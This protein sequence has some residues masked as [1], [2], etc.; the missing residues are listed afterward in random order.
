VGGLVAYVASFRLDVSFLLPFAAGNFV[1]IAASDLV[2][3]IN[4]PYSLTAN[5]LHFV[6][7]LAGLLLLLVIK[8]VL[9]NH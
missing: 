9:G 1:Y 2:P 3:E 7:F 6:L 8:I 5:I 4:R